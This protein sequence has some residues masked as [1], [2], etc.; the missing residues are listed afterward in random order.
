MQQHLP[1]ELLYLI[2]DELCDAPTALSRLS[3][4]AR[5]FVAPAQKLLFRSVDLDG[6][7]MRVVR[8]WCIAVTRKRKDAA[9]LAL[10]VRSLVLEL[11]EIAQFAPDDMGKVAAALKSC[12]NLKMLRLLRA[13]G[14]SG[15]PDV[16]APYVWILEQCTFQLTGF[17]NDY[18]YAPALRPFIEA[19]I[20]LRIFHGATDGAAL[21]D[22]LIG[23]GSRWS[24]S[25]ERCRLQRIETASCIPIDIARLR[26]C[27][28]S[29]TTL[30]L[31]GSYR[32]RTSPYESLVAVAENLPNIVHLAILVWS[33]MARWGRWRDS[34]PEKAMHGFSKLETFS[35]IL[36]HIACFS[37]EDENQTPSRREYLPESEHDMRAMTRATIEACPTLYRAVVGI[38]DGNQVQSV[39][40]ATRDSLG[41]VRVRSAREAVNFNALSMFWAPV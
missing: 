5:V 21:P 14:G 41:E 15:Y 32:S 27:S 40:T 28:Q 24:T 19:Q 10:L 36:R 2:C 22:N 33:D 30:N 12:T 16:T 35:Y 1:I 39:Y 4:S 38:E 6:S 25:H 7:S 31:L 3:R 11:P 29:L 13:S 26:C 8:G 23:Y 17:Q 18:F 37:M 9:P 20:H 34:A